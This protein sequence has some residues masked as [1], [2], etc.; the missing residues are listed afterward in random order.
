MCLKNVPKSE[1]CDFGGVVVGLAVGVHVEL[2]GFQVREA[3]VLLGQKRRAAYGSA[4]ACQE[5]DTF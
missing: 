5:T 4:P 1:G 2:S 3:Q